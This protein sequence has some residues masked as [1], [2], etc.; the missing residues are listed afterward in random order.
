MNGAFYIGATGLRSQE[1]ALDV[2]ANN[3]ANV[4]TPGY[5][6]SEIRFSEMVAPG[7]QGLSLSP[8][9]RRG[10]PTLSGV[11]A[12]SSLRV[13]SQGELRETGQPLDLAIEGEGFIELLGPGGQSRLWRGG[14]LRIDQDGY[15]AAADGTPLKAMVSTP[16]GATSIS[17][18]RDG[19][20]R[21]LLPGDQ[22]ATEIG[23]ID[24]VLVK[25]MAG[26]EPLGDGLYRAA[27]DEDL[28]TVTPG[29]DGGA[30]VQGA[31][32]TS[33]VELSEEM[34]ML[35]LMQRAYA[36][37]SQVIQAGDQLMSIANGL[38]R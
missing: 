13:F 15:L 12:A 33:N 7:S 17:I 8:T 38:R 1:R 14:T 36:A 2:T 9:A 32:E 26:L 10:A 4:N 27:D 20:V 35:L 25:D 22:T 28:I 5:K 3:I 34:V 31:V 16:V 37:N 24:L 29:E 11:S 6:R 23:Q 19:R 30:F 18:G 21:A